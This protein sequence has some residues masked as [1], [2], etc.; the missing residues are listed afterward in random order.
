MLRAKL[1]KSWWQHHTRHQLYGHLRPITKTVQDRR[2]RHA[3]HCWRSRVMYSYGPPH[4]AGQK[5]N[6]QLKHTFNSY[7]RIR[8]VAQKTSQKRWTIGRSGERGSGISMPVARYDDDDDFRRTSKL[9]E[10]NPSNRNLINEINTWTV[11]LII[12]TET[13]LKT[14]RKGTQTHGLKHQEANHYDNKR[15]RKRTC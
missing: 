2:T 4:M 9:L 13:F 10:I 7:V 6:D 3:S 14:T 1:N 11:S 5:Q 8:D 12:Y 15:K